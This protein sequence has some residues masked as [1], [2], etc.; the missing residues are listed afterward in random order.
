M[1]VVLLPGDGIGPE[2]IR[3]AVR[4]LR[5]VAEDAIGVP[6]ELSEEF[7]GGA[8]LDRYGDPLPSETLRACRKADAVLLGAVGGPAW[9]DA[10]VRPEAGLLRL[11]KE[12]AVFANLRP[13]RRS[14]ALSA[15]SPLRPEVVAHVDYLIVRE[16]TGGLYFGPHG[17]E[18][19]RVFDTL[20]YR[21]SEISRVAKVAFRQ[22]AARSETV[23]LVDK[24]NVLESSRM[25]REVVTEVSREFPGVAWTTELVDSCALHMVQDPGRYDVILTEN[26]FG[27]ILSD[28]GAG[29]LGSLGL[30][31]SASLGD[32]APVL[33]EPVHGS[34]PD[35]A[36]R[37]RANPL[38][39]IGA[40]AMMFRHSFGRPKAAD[41][42]EAA[43]EDV[44]TAGARTA[45]LA[46]PG[47]RPFSTDEMTNAVL[48]AI[49]RRL[50][51]EE[52]GK[53]LGHR[54]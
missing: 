36:G 13:I 23:T 14:P 41:L 49:D 38:G 8:A 19:S 20:V 54:A 24:A 42:V 27:D 1:K 4:V 53:A 26:L 15:S 29:T 22:A 48:K 18:G 16:L 46:G 31:P 10:P 40:V 30:L 50:T 47:E 21:K 34:A 25:W 52:G 51:E 33:Y 39:A 2:V 44:L 5:R 9:D 32:R 11:R 3:Q 35:I 28:L 37:G 43:I 45:D 12:L 17:R 7:V 6:L